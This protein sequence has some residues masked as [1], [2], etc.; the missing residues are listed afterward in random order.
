MRS[1]RC[2]VFVCVRVCVCFV[3]FDS[4]NGM[5]QQHYTVV[6]SATLQELHHSPEGE[7]E[8][9]GIHAFRPR[10][11]NANLAGTVDFILVLL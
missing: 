5:I 3:P 7:G 9:E 4:G 2:C 6:R 10:D 1:T 8:R 11:P